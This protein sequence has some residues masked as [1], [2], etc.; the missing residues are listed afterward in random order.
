MTIEGEG[1]LPKNLRPYLALGGGVLALGL[2]PMFVRWAEAPGVVTSFYRMLIAAAVLTPLVL[3][4]AG[5]HGLPQGKALA[6]AALAGVFTALDH[7]FW[8][9]GIE[10]T[11]VA[12]AMLMNYISPLWVALFAML[13]W[14]ERLKPLFWVAL[15]VILAGAAMVL[16]GS[17]SIHPDHAVGDGLAI[18]SSFFYAGYFLAAQRG[19]ET[20]NALT[21][22]WMATLV[23]SVCL[24]AATQALRMPLGGY[25]RS[26]YLIFI[27]AAIVSQ[28]GG[29]YMIVYAMGNLPA[30]VVA[31]SMV[32][33]PVLSALL[34]IPLAGEPLGAHQV[35]GG[36]VTLAG[37]YLVNISH[38]KG[39]RRL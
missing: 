6:V 26:T 22:L 20:L 13:V 9:L 39:E 24:L 29:L 15:A 30:S 36:A 33:Q 38:G 19:R 16:G 34:A 3:R 12:N 32:L 31:P 35:L 4:Q 28:L 1:G 11:S 5:K 2:S 14:R 27:A 8:S 7:G 18:I 10:R 21:F 17:L 23:G 37:V 25:S